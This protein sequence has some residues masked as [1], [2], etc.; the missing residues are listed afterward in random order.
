MTH[1]AKDSGP[2]G[3]FA[4][5]QPPTSSATAVEARPSDLHTS[6]P[7]HTSL[8][9][10]ELRPEVV[11]ESVF[12]S[13]RVVDRKAFG[14]LS[15][16]LRGLVER[17]AT[18]RATIATTLEQALAASKTAK[19]AELSQAGNLALA[20]KALKGLDE[21]IARANKLVEDAGDA[22]KKLDE[23]EQRAQ[24]MLDAK[25]AALE[26]QAQLAQAATQARVEALEQRI[27]DSSRE[28]E[29]RVDALRRDAG[30]L[31]GQN[32]AALQQN[33]T[34]AE[35]ILSGANALKDLVIRGESVQQGAESVVRRLEDAQAVAKTS[36][37]T[38]SSLLDELATVMGRVDAQR[39]SL[40]VEADRVREAC[41]QAG[42]AIDQRLLA[43][44]GIALNVGDDARQ[45]ADA[46]MLEIKPRIE[47][48]AR[49]VAAAA[50]DTSAVLNECRDIQNQL[51]ATIAKATDA[52][53]TTG[54]SLRL[55][56]KASSDVHALL[57]ALEPWKRMMDAGDQVEVPA[58]VRAMFDAV[59][60][61]L[62]GELATIATALRAAATCADRT[63][64][65]VDRSIPAQ[66]ISTKIVTSGAASAM[67]G[68][69]MRD[70]GTM[71]HA[72]D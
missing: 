42:A 67:L 45:A 65:A 26:A 6:H 24:K 70:R 54:A 35:N 52:Q 23:L 62:K 20:A 44:Q 19:D 11:V 34:R 39:E 59:R 32:V 48:A 2:V 49:E 51:N 4:K 38:L 22:A 27:R 14:E 63:M 71:A 58:P 43:A 37:D 1:S 36:R 56:D 47:A 16:E 41:K 68:T 10:G 60:S 29:Q 31:V 30:S 21:R 69:A 40:A 7:S 55:V 33:I 13:P 61:D 72:A 66:S 57:A 53:T 12:L 15:G 64:N 17:A 18:E 9:R 8:T 28:I 46:A 50:T 25:L 5:G 3:T